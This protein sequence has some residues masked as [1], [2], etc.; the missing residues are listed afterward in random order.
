[1]RILTDGTPVTPETATVLRN[2]IESCLQEDLFSLVIQPT[3]NF[4]TGCTCTGEALSRLNHPEYGIISAEIFIPIL[5]DLGLYSKF[6]QYI[7][8][9]CC[10]WLHRIA[11]EGKRFDWISCNFSRKTLSRT[12]IV[13]DLIRI[14]DSY[15][16][17]HCKLGIEITEW[18]QA[19]DMQQI[20]ENLRQLKAAGFRIILDDYGSGVTEESDLHNFPL[21]IVKLDHS[22]IL[23]TGT[24]QGVAAFRTLVAK[25]LQLGV[26]IICEGIETENQDSLAQETGCHYGQGFLYYKPIS[27]DK[28]LDLIHDPFQ[29]QA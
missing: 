27:H 22:L 8:R 28:V 11:A 4:R 14:A 18:N 13:Q 2:Q 16:V 7:F 9:K 10:M 3:V 19:T 24:E 26:E 5:D 15:E 6:D 17:P 23:N 20:S 12:D 25:F 1:M 21:D 29:N